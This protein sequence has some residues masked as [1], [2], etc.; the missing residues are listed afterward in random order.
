MLEQSCFRYGVCGR[1]WGSIAV[2]AK[3]GRKR[4]NGAVYHR[5]EL[6]YRFAA[7][8]AILEVFRECCLLVRGQ[9]A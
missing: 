8:R 9:L 2:I 6:L 3:M 4:R 7:L 1:A 5:F